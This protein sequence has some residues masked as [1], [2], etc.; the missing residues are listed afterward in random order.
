MNSARLSTLPDEIYLAEMKIF[1]MQNNVTEAKEALSAKEA[2]LYIQG[3]IDGKNAEIRN[4]QVKQFTA[5][6]RMA[7]SVAENKVNQARI[8]LNKLQ[9]TLTAYRAIAYMLKGAE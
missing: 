6:E 4:A 8:E 1:E 2:D 7:I 9:N 3:V 5:K